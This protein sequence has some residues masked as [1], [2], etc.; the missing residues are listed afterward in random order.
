VRENFWDKVKSAL[1][2]ISFAENLV[3][4]YYCAVDTRTPP[5]VRVTL[6]AT[7]AYFVMPFGPIFDAIVLAFALRM[8]AVHITPEHRRQARE[9]IDALSGRKRPA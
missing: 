1:G 9:M 7:L 2:R 3:A 6:F 5:Q 8:V 4:A